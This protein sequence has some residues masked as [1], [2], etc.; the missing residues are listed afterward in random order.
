MQADKIAVFFPGIGYHIDKPL[1]YFTRRLAREAGFEV[2]EISYTFPDK[3][4]E[5]KGNAGKMKDSFTLAVEQADAQLSEVAF[6]NYSK[7]LFIG[8]S[9]GTAVAA[10]Y[11]KEHGIGARHLILTPVP[12]TF[13][14]LR[15]GCG[16]VYHGLS[17][18]WCEN[19]IVKEMCTKLG[20]ELHE[21]ADANHSLE[22]GSAMKD[23]DNLRTLLERTQKFM[24]S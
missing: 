16:V 13:D 21:I 7:V 14:H 10:H 2:K 24:E 3:A 20:L 23:V 5:I 11:D 6:E 22:T 9:I 19:D 12:H 8:K 18:P 15:A 1:L 17:D 4:N